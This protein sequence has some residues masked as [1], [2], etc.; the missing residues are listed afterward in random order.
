MSKSKEIRV[1]RVRIA[2]RGAR[3]IYQAEY[4]LHG[5]HRRKSLKTANVKV[6]LQKARLLNAQLVTG[7]TPEAA[8]HWTIAGSVDAYLEHGHSVGKAKST[9]AIYRNIL[10]SHATW[11]QDHGQ[12][13]MLQLSLPSFEKYVLKL[14]DGRDPV[15][16]HNHATVIKQWVKWAAARGHIRDH[17]LRLCSLKKPPRKQRFVPSLTQVWGLIQS[18]PP[19]ERILFAVL[20]MTGMRCGELRHLRVEDIDFQHNWISIASRPGRET[21]TRSPRK[22][23]IHRVLRN[24]LESYAMPKR[25]LAFPSPRIAD[26]PNGEIELDTTALNKK[27]AANATEH[28]LPVGRETTGTTL[29]T[30]RRFFETH[31]VNSGIPQRCIDGWL[32]HTSDRSM[33]VVYYTLTDEQSQSFMRQLNFE[34][35]AASVS[36]QFFLPQELRDERVTD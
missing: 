15:T 11:C 32:G 33:G 18:A 25:G 4:S 20:A 3:G 30:F 10:T 34:C 5:K 28:G 7:E 1:D 14:R 23:P 31:A 21:K 13:K 29:H 19:P 22:I 16:V 36:V 9:I 6:A 8:Q 12:K 35:P 24:L 26:E 17:V 27:L 2:P